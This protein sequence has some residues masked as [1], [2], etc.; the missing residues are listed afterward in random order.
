MNILQ[1]LRQLHADITA[2]RDGFKIVDAWAL[3]ERLLTRLPVPPDEA[4]AVCRAKDADGLDRLL[5]RLEHPAPKVDAPLP[6]FSHDDLAAAI[7]AFKKR[8]KL[9]RLND[10]SRLGG[11]YTSGGRRSSIDAIEPPDGFSPDIWRVLARKGQLHD[12]GGGFYALPEHPVKDP[13]S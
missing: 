11:R 2:S 12:E 9:L 6:E 3:A 5:H 10:E 7:R 4:Q 8:L 13:H 1:K